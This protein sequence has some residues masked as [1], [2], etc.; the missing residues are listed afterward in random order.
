MILNFKTGKITLHFTAA[1]L[2]FTNKYVFY[3]RA[4]F[5]VDIC[6]GSHAKCIE[7]K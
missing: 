6:D 1:S 2:N 4:C 3:T 7:H 5:Y